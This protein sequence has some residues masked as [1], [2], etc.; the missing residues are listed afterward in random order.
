MKINL[1]AL[2]SLVFFSST[3]N[4]RYYLNGV[5]VQPTAKGLFL[6]ATDG[7]I[8]GVVRQ[9]AESFEGITSDVIIPHTLLDKIKLSR[10]DK[11]NLAE[12]SVSD[13]RVTIEY[14]GES[15]SA[16]VIDGIFPSWRSVFPTGKISG[17]CAQFTPAL[18][19]RIAKAKSLWSDEKDPSFTIAHNGGSVALADWF[20]PGYDCEGFGAIM[21]LRME[22][23]LDQ[24][25]SWIS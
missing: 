7:H 5:A 19:T 9:H 8:M 6:V 17:E 16:N 18:I 3:E 4:T 1:K 12:V 22:M 24:V 11:T 2:K 25:P 20:V 23:M 21:P 15:Y 13:G 14:F 10:K